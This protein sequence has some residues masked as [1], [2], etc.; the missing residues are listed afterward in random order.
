MLGKLVYASLMYVDPGSGLLLLQ[1]IGS[2]F[3]SGLLLFR[4][5]IYSLFRRH[6]SR[7]NNISADESE[8][9]ESCSKE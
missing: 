2:V 5:K 9:S 6:N 8:R 3:V 1:A 7:D 4:S